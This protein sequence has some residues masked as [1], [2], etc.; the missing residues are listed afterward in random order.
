MIAK[1]DKSKRNKRYRTNDKNDKN[2]DEKEGKRLVTPHH[3]P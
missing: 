2:L 3:T 1:I